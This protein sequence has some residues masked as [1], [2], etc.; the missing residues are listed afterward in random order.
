MESHMAALWIRC[1]KRFS[2]VTQSDVLFGDLLRALPAHVFISQLGTLSI[3]LEWKSL[4]FLAFIYNQ[5]IL[6]ISCH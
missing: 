3:G 6:L 2:T 5:F 1:V 4:Q